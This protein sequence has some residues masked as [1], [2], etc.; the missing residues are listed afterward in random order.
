MVT[1]GY[2]GVNG[3]QNPITSSVY[4]AN[5]IQS[6]IRTA[7]NYNASGADSFQYCP[8]SI[9][10]Y[11][12]EDYI[13]NV[14]KTNPQLRY[15]LEENDIPAEINM[16]NLCHIQSNHASDTQAIAK[17]IIKHLPQSERYKIDTNAVNKASYLHDIGKVFIPDEILN[18]PAKLDNNER[19][20]MQ[21]H[22]ELGY[23]ILKNSP[24]DE[25]TKQLVRY[26]HQNPLGSG[27]P[28]TNTD[29][30]ADLDLQILSAA[31][32]YSALTEHRSYKTALP[33]DKAL[34][35][36][37]SDVQKN[38]IHPVVFRGLAAHLN[39]EMAKLN[40]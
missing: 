3:Y 27:Y 26:H 4:G 24:L 22:S 18:K 40:I 29:F 31:D 20:I 36:I 34:G 15:I 35:V 2:F 13:R 19:R 1:S 23:E 14:L 7:R 28:V 9:Q 16:T 8:N 30:N 17:G 25:K 32:K 6:N 21:A 10:H 38:L 11:L 5:P 37:Y 12:K 33:Q 39:D